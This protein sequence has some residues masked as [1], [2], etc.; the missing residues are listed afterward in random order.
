[1][2]AATATSLSDYRK[3]DVIRFKHYRGDQDY[4]FAPWIEGS[5]VLGVQGPHLHVGYYRGEGLASTSL[6]LDPA[7]VPVERTAR[8]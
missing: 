3:W 6:Y 5:I 1:V 8:P 4:T 2:I 7:R